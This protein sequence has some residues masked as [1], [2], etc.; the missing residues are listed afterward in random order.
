MLFAFNTAVAPALSLPVA[1]ASARD[2]GY[3]GLEVH[4]PNVAGDDPAAGTVLSERDFVKL[5]FE[6]DGVRLVGLSVPAWFDAGGDAGAA[7]RNAATADALRRAI[8]LAGRLRC[9]FVRVLVAAVPPGSALAEA[10]VRVADWLVPLADHAAGA[11]TTLLVRNALAF[12]MA[13]PLWRVIDQADHPALGVAWDPLAAAVAGEEPGLSVPTLNSR[14][15]LVV[16]RDARLAG[17]AGGRRVE[18][19]CRPG[20]GDL[21]LKTLA[22]RLRGV[23]FDGPVVVAYPADL[24]SDVG[25][26]EALLQAATSQFRHWK[27]PPPPPAKS[28]AT[29]PGG[30]PRVAGTPAPQR[31]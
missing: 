9:P 24:P 6:R 7:G 29:K 17:P 23:G 16:L 13:G 1:T 10:A 8:D 3:D 27:P 2:L 18:S 4:L 21:P 26:H 11:G 28:T 12:R 31:A 19:L 30:T 5:V 20:E 14:I 25:P 15:R 22:A